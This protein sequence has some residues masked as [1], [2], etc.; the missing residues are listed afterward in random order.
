MTNVAIVHVGSP[1]ETV[2]LTPLIEGVQRQIKGAK[3]H[4]I[5]DEGSLPL[6]K[7]NNK[8]ASISASLYS[9]TDISIL[10]NEKFDLIINFVNDIKVAEFLANLPCCSLYGYR[11]FKESVQPSDRY[12]NTFFDV[13]SNKQI[14][15]K[16]L[17]KL[18][19]KMAGLT[20]RGECYDISYYPKN[21]VKKGK[22]GIAI[23][24]EDLRHYVKSNLNLDK[25]EMWHIPLRK[26]LLKRIDEINR[27]KTIITDDLFTVYSG[28]ALRKN[29]QFLDTNNLKYNIEFFNRG[30]HY[31]I[32]NREF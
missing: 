24:R 1:W 7:F 21:K 13:F 2:F 32:G 22:V 8:L 4:W 3:I 9:L 5:T 29:I 12:A 14:S 31:R 16:T 25:G 6:L 15:N 17:L 20:W 27:C 23:E 30:N 28:L 11:Y 19:F 10:S 26:N 18:M